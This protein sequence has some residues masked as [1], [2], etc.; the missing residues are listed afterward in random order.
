MNKMIK[1]LMVLV[2]LVGC[3]PKIVD[4]PKEKNIVNFAVLNGPTGIGSAYLLE[5][6]SNDE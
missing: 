5:R 6:N 2:L 4:E 3:T 1:L